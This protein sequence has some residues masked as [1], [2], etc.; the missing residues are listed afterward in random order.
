MRRDST[1]KMFQEW[2]GLRHVLHECASCH[3]VGLKP[4]ILGTKHGDYGMRQ[5]I[6]GKFEEMRIGPHGL[7]DRCAEEAGVPNAS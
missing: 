5:A 1:E 3:T 6:K 2:P 7:C 4:G